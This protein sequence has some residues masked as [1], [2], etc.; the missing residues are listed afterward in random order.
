MNKIQLTPKHLENRMV[1]ILIWVDDLIIGAS[2][3]SLM[4]HT[5]QML[6]AKF[7]RNSSGDEIAN[8]NFLNL[9]RHLYTH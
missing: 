5:K 1:V 3:D 6:K 9:R 8:V 2:D 7:T 4:C